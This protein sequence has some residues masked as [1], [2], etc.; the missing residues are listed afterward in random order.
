MQENR[1]RICEKRENKTY[2]PVGIWAVF[3]KLYSDE[4][5]DM[6]FWSPNDRNAYFKEIET[7]YHY[8]VN[9]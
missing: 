8:F 6:K 2:V 5:L 9:D 3:N 4:V 7:A 1:V